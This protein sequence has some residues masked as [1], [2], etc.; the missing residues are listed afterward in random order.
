VCSRKTEVPG[1]NA[2]DD[3]QF[4]FEFLF[5]IQI[6]YWTPT[7]GASPLG[8]MTGEVYYKKTNRD[9]AYGTKQSAYQRGTDVLR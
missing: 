1:G 8:R 2:A 6:R 4:T 5:A 7:E 3:S 9:L